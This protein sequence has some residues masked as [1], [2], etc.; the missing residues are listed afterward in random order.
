MLM[1]YKNKCQTSKN[2]YQRYRNS[3]TRPNEHVVGAAHAAFCGVEV[4]H[5]AKSYRHFKCQRRSRKSALLLLC[6][7]PH[8][9]LWLLQL[10]RRGRLAPPQRH[11][12]QQAQF[13][14]PQADKEH[15]VTLSMVGRDEMLCYPFKKST[16]TP[17]S[18]FTYIIHT[19]SVLLLL[20]LDQFKGKL[21]I[22]T[23]G[24][25]EI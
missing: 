10:I 21:N 1:I 24:R 22:S 5:H 4:E 9:S 20:N 13:F 14:K 15:N 8:Q 16:V 25:H 6:C 2:G 7:P 17:T 3:K 23:Q 12:H 11:Q 19:G 18:E